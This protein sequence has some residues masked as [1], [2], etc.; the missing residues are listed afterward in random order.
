MKFFFVIIVFSVF[1]FFGNAQQ[2]VPFTVSTGGH[3]MINAEIDGVKGKFIFD[4]GAGLNLVTKNY[5]DK[6]KGTTTDNTFFTGFRA[7]GD[8]I[9]LQLYSA[10]ELIIGSFKYSNPGITYLDLNWGDID[11]ILSLKNF[12]DAIVTLDYN[13]NVLVI[14][15]KKDFASIKKSAKAII[16]IQITN[17]RGVSLGISC[18][19]MINGIQKAQLVLDSGAGKD[20][21]RVNSRYMPVLNIDPKD[22]LKVEK[23]VR[24][25][26]M[27][28]GHENV[29]YKAELGSIAIANTDKVAVKNVKT[30][31]V[32][33]L[34]YDGIV[35]IDW[36]GKKI[37]IS[38]PTSEI[39]V[40]EF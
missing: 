14:E 38:V 32:D 30:Q 27:K 20:V 36:L 35:P 10:K 17:T 28:E 7:T 21:Y 18:Y 23:I 24:K 9:D 6:L 2:V 26:E 16:P 13:K 31:F 5:F 3:M 34:I 1:N 8:R 40:S 12:E 22:T 33:G 25:S 11:G 4:T 29:M 19:A 37:T 39:I 15:N